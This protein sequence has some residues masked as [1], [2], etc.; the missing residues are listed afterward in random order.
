[1]KAAVQKLN[2]PLSDRKALVLVAAAVALLLLGWGGWTLYGRMTD[3]PATP[4][5]VKSAIRKYLAKKSGE[6]EFKAPLDIATAS[7]ETGLSSPIIATV[8]NAVTTTN[9]AGRVRTVNKVSKV[10]KAGRPETIFTSYFR[11][12]QA[13]CETYEQMYRLIGQQ[14]AVADQLLASPE[15]SKQLTALLMASEA[16]EYART[17]TANLWLGARICEGYLWPNLALTETTNRSPFTAES[18]LTL[19]DTA[20]QE[21]GE[22][23]NIIRNYEYLIAK[24]RKP[25]QREVACYRLAQIYKDL[26]QYAKAVTLLKEIKT[27]KIAKVPYEIAFL[28]Q[29]MRRK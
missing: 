18:L 9:K 2:Q 25:A 6:K 13:Q 14:L 10:S 16:G 26:G 29:K 24:S 11:T 8:T 3:R 12:N 1:M 19:C 28:E 7:A 4:A 27:Y 15:A 20:F 23:N 5:E 22:T 17:T 21:A